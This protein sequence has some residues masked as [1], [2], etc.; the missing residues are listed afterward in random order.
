MI[1]RYKVRHYNSTAWHNYR[2]LWPISCL[3]YCTYCKY[4]YM[5]S[6]T[7]LYRILV[8]FYRCSTWSYSTFVI[9]VI[10][11]YSIWQPVTILNTVRILSHKSQ[12]LVVRH[13]IWLWQ[14]HFIISKIGNVLDLALSHS[15]NK[16][17]SLILSCVISNKYKLFF[18]T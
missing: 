6:N 7:V 15:A 8:H 11:R 2:V 3:V 13:L 17:V 1:Y 4:F 18:I 12:I 16:P 10:A 14:L 5:L 9:T